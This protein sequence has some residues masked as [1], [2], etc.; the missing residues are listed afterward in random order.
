[1][2]VWQRVSRVDSNGG[3]RNRC[4]AL[5]HPPTHLPLPLPPSNRAAHPS[6][7]LDPSLFSYESRKLSLLRPTP[8]PADPTP[9]AFVRAH[10]SKRPKPTVG[11]TGN[12]SAMH[13]SHHSWERGVAGVAKTGWVAGGMTTGAVGMGVAKVGVVGVTGGL[14]GAGAGAGAGGSGGGGASGWGRR[15]RRPLGILT[16]LAWP[17]KQGN[18]G[19]GGGLQGRGVRGSGVCGDGSGSGRGGDAGQCSGLAGSGDGHGG[20]THGVAVRDVAGQG[21][22]GYTDGAVAGSSHPPL[23]PIADHARGPTHARAL[24]PN[25]PDTSISTSNRPLNRPMG[26]PDRP[27]TAAEGRGRLTGMQV[28]R[29]VM[30]VWDFSRGAGGHVAPHFAVPTR[31]WVREGVLSGGG[32]GVGGLGA[33][34]GGGGAGAV[35]GIGGQ[36]AVASGP[37]AAGVG[38]GTASPALTTAT[39]AALTT[40]TPAATPAPPVSTTA[41]PLPPRPALSSAQIKHLFHPTLPLVV[42]QCL[43]PGKPIQATVV[44]R[45]DEQGWWF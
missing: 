27:A 31:P 39:P 22:L 43:E 11:T 17:P 2:C 33:G 37:V 12:T 24:P 6:P 7:L 45:G 25:P 13:H 38:V 1:M 10:R 41:T 32:G 30:G 9:V 18:D 36:S 14:A 16:G 42:M 23:P 20:T 35:A 21:K 34:A 26:I 4:P 44:C 28:V 40:V 5:P 29:D 19:K 15:L 3:V 8:P